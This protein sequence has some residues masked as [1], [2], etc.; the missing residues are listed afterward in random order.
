MFSQR[1]G[2]PITNIL[3]QLW[4]VLDH[5]GPGRDDIERVAVE[6]TRYMTEREAEKVADLIVDFFD[7]LVEAGLRQSDSGPS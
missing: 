6:I 2:H 4:E 5:V 3:N 7:E 1:A